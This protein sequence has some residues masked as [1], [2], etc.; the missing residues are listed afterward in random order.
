MDRSCRKL[1][2]LFFEHPALLQEVLTSSSAERRHFRKNIRQYNSALVMASV[3]SEF[4]S[5]D[6][7]VFKH[8]PIITVHGRIYHEIGAFQP[9]DGVLPQ[10][11]S[12]S[13][14]NT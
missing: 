1:F 5:R 9:A 2:L 10:Y 13:I 12:V 4:V 6:P 7:G 8:N 3:R 14:H 11:A